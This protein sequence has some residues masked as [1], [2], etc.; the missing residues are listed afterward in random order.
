M[1]KPTWSPSVFSSMSVAVDP[2]NLM[3]EHLATLRRHGRQALVE[4]QPLSTLEEVDRASRMEEF[5]ALGS[6]FR[7]TEKE[8]VILLYKDL[9]FPRSRLLAQAN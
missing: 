8:M 5:F 6:S 4:G 3:N 9:F 1:T 2:K 7:L